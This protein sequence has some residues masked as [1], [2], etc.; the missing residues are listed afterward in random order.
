MYRLFGHDF[1]PEQLQDLPGELSELRKLPLLSRC[2]TAFP[3]LDTFDSCGRRRLRGIL[4]AKRAINVD[5]ARQVK[6]AKTEP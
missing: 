3:N 1:T 2:G 5:D 4:R 6:K